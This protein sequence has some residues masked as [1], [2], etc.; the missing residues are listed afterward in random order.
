LNALHGVNLVPVQTTHKWY[1]EATEED[2]E[3]MYILQTLPPSDRELVPQEFTPNSRS[4]FDATF[5][6]IREVYTNT[7]PEVVRQWEEFALLVPLQNASAQDHVRAHPNAM[8]IPFKDLLFSFSPE[9]RAGNNPSIQLGDDFQSSR[10]RKDFQEMPQ[11]R[12][13]DSISW[14]R[15]NKKLR[16]DDPNSCL[17][18]AKDCPPAKYERKNKKKTKANSSSPQNQ[19]INLNDNKTVRSSRCQSSKLAAAARKTTNRRNSNRSSSSD[20]E[21]SDY[22]CYSD[23]DSRRSSHS[24]NSR[25]S[26]SGNNESYSG[27]ESSDNNDDHSDDDDENDGPPTSSGGTTSSHQQQKRMY[28]TDDEKLDK[29]QYYHKRN[30]VQ[31]PRYGSALPYIDKVFQLVHSSGSRQGTIKA[32]VSLAGDPSNELHFKFYDQTLHDECPDSYASDDDDGQ[33]WQ[34]IKCSELMGSKKGLKWNGANPAG[35]GNALVGMMV[36]RPFRVDKNWTWFNGKVSKYLKKGYY[37][38]TYD[39]GDV[40]TEKELDVVKFL[41]YTF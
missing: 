22:S 19:T 29:N 40:L 5:R 1:P 21:E 37:E 12:S 3:G 33:I 35:V 4:V 14:S 16:S 31:V 39:D 18:V 34:Y 6:K 28:E 38:V 13:T 11:L 10:K 32:V 23:S 41:M 9:E 17:R 24:A 30:N 20:D 26:S 36:R 7:Q 15:R 25:S 8:R 2:P 27:G